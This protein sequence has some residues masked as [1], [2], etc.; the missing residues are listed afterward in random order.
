MRK[1][2]NCLVIIILIITVIALTGC[3]TE[4]KTEK[5]I[6]NSKNESSTSNNNNSDNGNPEDTNSQTDINSIDFVSSAQKQVA[7]P[8]KGDTIA[9]LHIKDYGNITVKF[10][11]D[12]A[13][14]AVENFITHAKNGY[15]NGVTFHR[16]ID[17]FMI[18]GGD[19]TA[20]GAGGE[21]IWKED[22]EDEFSYDLLPYRGALC[23]ANAG[24]NTNGSQFFIEQANYDEETYNLLKQYN[25]PEKLLESYKIYGGSM[26]LFGAHTVF[27]QVI[28]GMDVVDKIAKVET[29]SKAKPVED[30][31]IENIEITQY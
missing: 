18:Q 24:S 19:P 23:M 20:T 29:D 8:N 7:M 27:G 4:N 26:H 2:K 25:Y 21:S 22:F 9:I 12:V 13:P 28:D 3:G 11:S 10:F 14:K 17:N 30:V 15:Y 1:I 5:N 6:S 16:V 31:V